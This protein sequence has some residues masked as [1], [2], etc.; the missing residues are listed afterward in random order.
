MFS[1]LIT[2]IEYCLIE[3]S[4]SLQMSHKTI[5]PTFAQLCVHKTDVL[6]VSGITVAGR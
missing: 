6:K 1:F 3:Y 2:V 5:I 4:A